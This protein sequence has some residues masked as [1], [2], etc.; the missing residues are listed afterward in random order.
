MGF[1]CYTAHHMFVEFIPEIPKVAH[2]AVGADPMIH[3]IPGVFVHAT[4]E[5]AAQSVESFPRQSWATG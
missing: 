5:A 3:G 4:E 2:V 1:H